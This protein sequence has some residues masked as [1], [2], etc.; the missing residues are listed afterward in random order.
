MSQKPSPLGRTAPN[1]RSLAAPWGPGCACSSE[2]K[3]ERL[4]RGSGLSPERAQVQ[5]ASR[6]FDV[7]GATKLRLDRRASCARVNASSKSMN[8]RAWL[9]LRTANRSSLVRVESRSARASSSLPAFVKDR[10]VLRR[11]FGYSMRTINP[12]SVRIPTTTLVVHRSKETSRP[13]SFCPT[14]P[15]RRKAKR[16]EY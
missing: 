2:A 4:E 12:R 13:S 10:S 16:I 11:S 8:V 7:C 15:Q 5:R 1:S 3:R 6:R 14:D 9:L